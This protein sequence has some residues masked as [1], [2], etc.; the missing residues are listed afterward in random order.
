MTEK[1][2]DIVTQNWWS[3]LRYSNFGNQ[4]ASKFKEKP[5]LQAEMR[6]MFRM[7]ND[8]LSYYDMFQ[9]VEHVLGIK[10]QNWEED[11]LEGRLDRLGF[12]F[13]E[14]NEFNEFTMEYG[15]DWNEALL[16]T[17]LEDILDAKLNLSY[18]DYVVT[19]DDYFQGVSTMLTTEKAA[20]AA[21]TNIYKQ[22]KSKKKGAKGP[23]AGKYK[24]PDFGPKSAEDEDGSR[25]AMYK[26]GEMP[27]KGY[28]N[29]KKVSWMYAD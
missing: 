11:A 25:F 3:K 21:A 6:R 4:I 12:A 2:E 15:V 7:Q 18:K 20:L 17:D 14:F 1:H 28:P 24:D 13:I 27:R 9:F 23:G 8:K 16:E 19:K 22:L 26:T 5:N 29:P 10:L